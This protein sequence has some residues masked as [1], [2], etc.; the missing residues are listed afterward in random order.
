MKS[1]KLKKLKRS[2]LLG[3]HVWPNKKLTAKQ[4]AKIVNKSSRSMSDF[5]RNLMNYRKYTNVYGSLGKSYMTRM[6]VRANCFPGQKHLNLLYMLES[7]LDVCL[8]RAGFGSSL[9]EICQV[10]S[11]KHVYVNNKYAKCSS[12]E[13]NPGDIA[14]IQKSNLNV[15]N[16][17]NFYPNYPMNIEVDYANLSLIYLYP[18]QKV[19]LPINPTEF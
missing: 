4:A 7:R 2:Y 8:Y 9:D 11:H 10:V 19:Y 12:Q 16:W 6:D 18:P 1:F 14:Q 13:L 5:G 3:E 15:P 17:V